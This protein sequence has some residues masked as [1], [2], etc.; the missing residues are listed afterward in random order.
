MD[1]FSLSPTFIVIVTNFLKKQKTATIT[2][3]NERPQ[4]LSFLSVRMS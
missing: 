1:I 3:L 2:I 4:V